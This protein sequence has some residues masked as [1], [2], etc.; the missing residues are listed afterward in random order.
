MGG[1]IRILIVD[2]LD[3][4][5]DALRLM[6]EQEED[7]EIV[8]DFATAEEALSQ[9]ETLSPDIV[10]MDIKMPGMNGIEACRRLKETAPSCNV[11][12]LTMY[13]EYTV[14]AMIAGAAA[15]FP[16]HRTH[17]QLCQTI[18]QVYWSEGS[19]EQ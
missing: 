1:N 16:K 4:I 18:R 8:G 13:E 17:G 19:I 7:M 15:Y 10:L 5:R 14:E 11:I 2:D 9:V 12:M 3:I 6:L